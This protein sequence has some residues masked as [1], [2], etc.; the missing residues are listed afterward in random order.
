MSI[1]KQWPPVNSNPPFP[2]LQVASS[3]STVQFNLLLPDDYVE[4]WAETPL[5]SGKIKPVAIRRLIERESAPWRLLR[6]RF[7]DILPNLEYRLLITVN[8]STDCRWFKTL[9]LESQPLNFAF[10]NCLNDE[11]IY[12]DIQKD[13]YHQL[14]LERPDLLILGGDLVYVD[15]R[16]R[17]YNIPGGPRQADCLVR[18]LET[19]QRLDLFKLPY[20]IPTITIWDDHDYGINDG[21]RNFPYKETT[22]NL[23]KCFY[24][25]DDI[26]GVFTNFNQGRAAI[27]KHHQQAFLLLDNRYF[28]LHD[29]ISIYPDL[30]NISELDY[31]SLYQYF[32][33]QYSKQ[34]YNLFGQEQEDWLIAQAEQSDHQFIWLVGGNQFFGNHHRKESYSRSNPENFYHFLERIKKVGKPFAILSGDIHVSEFCRY[35]VYGEDQTPVYEFVISPMH[36]T[37]KLHDCLPDCYQKLPNPGRIRDEILKSQ[38]SHLPESVL[39][40]LTTHGLVCFRYNFGVFTT[41][42]VDKGDR[43]ALDTRVKL[44]TDNCNPFFYYN[45][46]LD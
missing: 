46:E 13:I 9:P 21:D 1:P 23:H 45:V 25:A 35:L 31:L 43:L 41:Q 20:L 22:R 39:E 28:R 37:M 42:L 17:W 29:D 34:R 3:T 33:K 32:V 5:D 36:S 11:T 7:T 40:N 27:F 6:V 19:W 38:N 10:G 4:I 16:E 15:S 44:V 2:I 26:A 24:G 30:A 14:S 8:G 12:I 18:Y